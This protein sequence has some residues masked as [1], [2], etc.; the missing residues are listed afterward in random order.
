MI[1]CGYLQIL[2]DNF[3]SNQLTL[4]GNI[5]ISAPENNAAV[6]LDNTKIKAVKEA[7]K[8][9]KEKYNF[10]EVDNVYGLTD[11]EIKF[12]AN[13]KR[14]HSS[15]FLDEFNKL[16]IAVLHEAFKQDDYS[17][18]VNIFGK[19][20][21]QDNVQSYRYLNKKEDVRY[22]IV[23]EEKRQLMDKVFCPKFYAAVATMAVAVYLG[24]IVYEKYMK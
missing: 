14:L 16:L 6:V 24:Y 19:Y 9:I 15:N 23:D 17:V 21:V 20:F 8:D 10:L 2:K 1:R 12:F 11:I 13:Q 3:G 4:S 5:R 18:Q 7:V 22:I